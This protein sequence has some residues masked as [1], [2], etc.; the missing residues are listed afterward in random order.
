MIKQITVLSLEDMIKHIPVEPTVMISIGNSFEAECLPF[1]HALLFTDV[2][3]LKFEDCTEDFFND[4]GDCIARPMSPVQ[5]MA[6]IRF[7][8]DWNIDKALEVNMIVHCAAGISRSPGVAVS[9]HKI[10]NI[11]VVCPPK[12]IPSTE[13]PQDWFKHH[14]RRVFN[15]MLNVAHRLDF[16]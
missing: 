10:F 2:L 16:I 7:T 5:A 6:A 14:N 3:P 1:Q 9:L 13:D 11:P 12:I 8:N 15:L 4:R